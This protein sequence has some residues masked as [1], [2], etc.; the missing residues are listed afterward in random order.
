MGILKYIIKAVLGLLL[1]YWGYCNLYPVEF[2]EYRLVEQG[3]GGWYVAPVLARLVVSLKFMIGIFLVLNINPKNILPKLLTPLMLLHVYDIIWGY[4]TEGIVMHY[5]YTEIIRGD[6]LLGLIALILFAAL[7]VWMLIKPCSTDI[8]VWW[9]KYP[10]GIAVVSLPFILN[11]IFPDDLKDVAEYE[12]EPFKLEVINSIELDSLTQKGVLVGFFST[13]C[14]YC[15][16]AARK[17]K[18]SQKRWSGFPPFYICFLGQKG[19]SEYFLGMAHADFPFQPLDRE[20]YYQLSD[21]RFPKFA[22]V[23]NGMVKKRWDGRTFNY[24]TLNKLSKGE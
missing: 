22:W 18:I 19:A 7:I 13:N 6:K 11:A 23:E 24:Y 16:N 12:E 9:I 2:F 3:I 4:I 10:I 8:K 15:L 5:S 1:I 21:G 14:P 20:Q 17:I